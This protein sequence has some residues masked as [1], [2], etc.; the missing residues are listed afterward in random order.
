NTVADILDDPQVRD[1]GLLWT[2]ERPEG[3]VTV[4]G[5]PLRFAT[6]PLPAS[7]PPKLGADT[8]DVLAEAG[9]DEVTITALREAG[10]VG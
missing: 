7:P 3:P 4:V 6:G 8:D 5:S 10:F 9:V 2:L 1:Q